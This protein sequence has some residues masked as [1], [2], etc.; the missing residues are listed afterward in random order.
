[1]QI[2][3][4]FDSNE[5]YPEIEEKAARLAYGLIS[6]HGFV[7]GNKRIGVYAMLVF[8]ELNNVTLKFTQDEL[9]NLGLGTA[10]GELNYLDILDFIKSHQH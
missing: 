5:L 2:D 9:I 8:L 10:K 1:M 7:D 3:Q 4:T 6:N